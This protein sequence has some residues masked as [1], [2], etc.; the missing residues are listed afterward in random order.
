MKLMEERMKSTLA[1]KDMEQDITFETAYRELERIVAQLE[2][3][4]GDLEDSLVNYERGVRLVR[5]CRQKLDG[6]ARRIELLKG[7]DENGEIK[8]EQIDE[9]ALL[10][11]IDG[12]GRQLRA[13]VK[14]P[15]GPSVVSQNAN[16]SE[17]D[18]RVS[19]KKPRPEAKGRALGASFFSDYDDT[20]P[21]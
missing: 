16:A 10:A 20:P 4:R 5:I 17:R 13:A 9:A 11:G 18:A 2:S 8:V 3:G 12:A 21:F 1:D 7:V 14:S 19:D 6:A 15:Q